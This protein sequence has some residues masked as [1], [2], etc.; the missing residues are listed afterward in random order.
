MKSFKVFLLMFS[1][2]FSVAPM[3]MGKKS[4]SE[5]KPL[6]APKLAS[7]LF[8]ELESDH[9]PLFSDWMQ[10]HERDSYLTAIRSGT[11][12]QFCYNPKSTLFKTKKDQRFLCPYCNLEI[13]LEELKINPDTRKVLEHFGNVHGA[14]ISS[15]PTLSGEIGIFNVTAFAYG[16]SNNNVFES[17]KSGKNK[18]F[19]FN[20]SGE[21]HLGQ[22]STII[23][24][25]PKCNLMV[26]YEG[27]AV[28]LRAPAMLEHFVMKHH[29]HL[30]SIPISGTGSW[31]LYEVNLPT[32]PY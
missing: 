11:R 27:E 13:K 30:E 1:L 23:C 17:L 7:E 19:I 9:T 8:V 21:L 18:R 14:R 12:T 6:L 3:A 4:S 5:K 26:K 28:S 20:P 29:A 25:L 10:D 22:N 15:I 2:F 31:P 16:Q 32:Q 24:P